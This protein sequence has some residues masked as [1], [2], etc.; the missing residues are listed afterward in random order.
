MIPVNVHGDV[1]V[2]NVTVFEGSA[3]LKVRIS[4][5]S[6]KKRRFTHSSGTP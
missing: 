3:R 4:R 5:S 6:F 1:D 2:H